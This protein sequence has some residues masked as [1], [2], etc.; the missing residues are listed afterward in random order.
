MRALIERST[1]KIIGL[2]P[3]GQQ[4]TISV[5]N[6]SGKLVPF[7]D[8]ALHEWDENAPDDLSIDD[9][10]LYT[11]SGSEYVKAAKVDEREALKAEILSEVSLSVD[12][13]IEASK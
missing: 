13:K 6:E 3:T 5:Y 4:A 7:F 2:W 10:L 12:S 9:V 1:G 8:P 11:K